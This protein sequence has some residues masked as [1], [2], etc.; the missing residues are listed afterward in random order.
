VVVCTVVIRPG[1]WLTI[2]PGTTIRVRGDC[3]SHEAMLWGLTNAGG[4]GAKPS[5]IIMPGWG[6]AR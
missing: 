3:D 1:A 5:I 4:A 6:C 2:Q